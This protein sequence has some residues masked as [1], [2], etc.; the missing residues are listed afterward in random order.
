MENVEKIVDFQ[1][2]CPKC[3]H[4]PLDMSE[5]PCN[6]CLMHATNVY[7]RKPVLF[8]EATQHDGS[9]NQR[10]DQSKT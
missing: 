4:W 10:A 7:S 1:A 5:Y 3:E 9:R 2:Y 6:E 8:K